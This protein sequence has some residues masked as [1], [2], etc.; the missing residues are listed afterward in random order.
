[1]TRKRQAPNK[2]TI[3]RGITGCLARAPM[4]FSAGAL[5]PIRS[6]AET[7]ISVA[8]PRAGERASTPP[9][10]T[11]NRGPPIVPVHASTKGAKGASLKRSGPSVNLPKGWPCNGLRLAALMA[12]ATPSALLPARSEVGNM[13][14]R[15]GGLTMRLVAAFAY[16]VMLVCLG[17]ASGHAEM[18]VA[19]V[20]GNGDYA[21]VAQSRLH[22]RRHPPGS[23]LE[24][25]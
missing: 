8:R 16:A 4:R 17:V 5:P 14:F 25:E 7:R 1:L 12:V 24:L 11:P 19:L 22:P 18:R 9:L 20:I 21:L 3:V 10:W 2:K 15:L 13:R 6:G 23:V